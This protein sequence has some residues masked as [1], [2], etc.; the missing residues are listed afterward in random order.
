MLPLIFEQL[1]KVLK[2]GAVAVVNDYMG[3]DGEVSQ[4]TR[5]HVMKRLHFE[6][7]HGHKAWRHIAEDAGLEIMYYQNLNRHMEEGYTLLAKEAS[8]FSFKSADGTP[9]QE[10]YKHSANAARQGHIGMNLAI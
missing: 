3:T 7:L 8:K 6:K 5:D 9:I 10:N 4:A 1:K 2:K